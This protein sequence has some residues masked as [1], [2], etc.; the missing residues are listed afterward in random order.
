MTTQTSASPRRAS[1]RSQRSYGGRVHAAAVSVGLGRR[2]SL[3]LERGGPPLRGP[4]DED[5][6]QIGRA[7]GGGETD[8][9]ERDPNRAVR[10]VAPAERVDDLLDGW[11]NEVERV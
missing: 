5:V 1:R 10:G 3:V 9:G 11:M 4:F 2:A 6:E 7:D 8:Q